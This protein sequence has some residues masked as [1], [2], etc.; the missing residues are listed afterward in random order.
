VLVSVEKLV[1]GLGLVGLGVVW[2]LGNMGRLDA[3]ETLHRWWPLLLVVWGALEVGLSV[4]RRQSARR[5]E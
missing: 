2:T 5:M 4:S 1:L 3:I